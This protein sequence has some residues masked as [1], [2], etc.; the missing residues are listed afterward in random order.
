MELGGVEVLDSVHLR[1]FRGPTVAFSR[2]LFLLARVFHAQSRIS[3][4]SSAGS[5]SLAYRAA[6]ARSFLAASSWRDT[7]VC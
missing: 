6:S 4:M 1:F 2:E 7:S 5:L 3:G